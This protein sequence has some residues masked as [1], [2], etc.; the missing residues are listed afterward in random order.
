[1]SYYGM[2]N[3][4]PYGQSASYGNYAPSSGYGG[5]GQPSPYGFGQSASYGSP[6]GQANPYGGFS[7][8]FGASSLNST[9]NW[10][11]MNNPYMSGD[12]QLAFIDAKYGHLFNMGLQMSPQTVMPKLWAAQKTSVENYMKSQF[13]QYTQAQQGNNGGG[14]NL[15]AMLPTLLGSLGGEGG[16]D[17]MK[18]LPTLFSS[19]GGTPS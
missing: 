7:A 6:Y 16:G 17:L 11:M 8:G 2:P 13:Q 1:M 9:P 10:Q 4:N 12:Q 5:Y 15:M 18:M 19:M 14:N 3:M